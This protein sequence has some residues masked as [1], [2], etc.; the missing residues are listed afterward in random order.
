M[1]ERHIQPN[2]KQ[3]QQ[4]LVRDGKTSLTLQ[5]PLPKKTAET[6]PLYVL[7]SRLTVSQL[8]LQGASIAIY[9]TTHDG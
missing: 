1:T 4:S 5:P 6:L 8:I 2:R 7:H 3:Q 9:V